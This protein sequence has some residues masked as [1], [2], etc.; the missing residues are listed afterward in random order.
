M[1][2][3]TEQF[4]LMKN[5][6]D[7]KITELQKFVEDFD[8]INNGLEKA[9]TYVNDLIATTSKVSSF[10]DTVSEAKSKVQEAK[11]KVSNF[12]GGLW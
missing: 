10:K 6:D 7:T 1:K 4:N 12:F 5:F 8:K 11:S 3:I 2:A 9:N